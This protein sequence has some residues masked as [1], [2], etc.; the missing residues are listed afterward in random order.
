LNFNEN[1]KE[2]FLYLATL[3]IQE[4]FREVSIF[5]VLPRRKRGKSKNLNDN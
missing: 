1:A 2:K 4:I 5:N 3:R